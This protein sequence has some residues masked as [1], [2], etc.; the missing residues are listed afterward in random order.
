[1]V[2]QIFLLGRKS[3]LQ[4]PSNIFAADTQNSFASFMHNI[5]ANIRRELDSLSVPVI[6]DLFHSTPLT[7]FLPVSGYFIHKL[8]SQS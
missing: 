2:Q 7:C 3:E 8:I 4:L 1:M 5:I 6:Y